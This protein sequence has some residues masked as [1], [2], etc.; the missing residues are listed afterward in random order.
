MEVA[1]PNPALGAAL[2][3]GE[4]LHKVQ[5]LQ[6]FWET[7]RSENLFLQHLERLF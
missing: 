3:E 5:A 6:S 7:V 2:G 1:C 4:G